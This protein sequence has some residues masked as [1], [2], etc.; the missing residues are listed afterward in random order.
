MKHSLDGDIYQPVIYLLFPLDLLRYLYVFYAGTFL[1]KAAP[2]RTGFQ[3]FTRS[4]ILI[5]M[6]ES[7]LTRLDCP[8]CG[9]KYDA[10]R[11]QGFCGD[12][13]SP[14]LARH[15]LNMVAA[16]TTYARIAPARGERMSRQVT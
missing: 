10:D 12:C 8:D 15:R 5:A 1:W 6:P 9:K 7:A 13:R 11:V 2:R 4:S 14:L 16:S 3:F